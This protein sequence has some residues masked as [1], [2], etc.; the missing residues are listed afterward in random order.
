MSDAHPEDLQDFLEQQLAELRHSVDAG[1]GKV[2]AEMAGRLQ[3][4]ATLRASARSIETIL[5]EH[6]NR[7]VGAEAG[8]I[9][10]NLSADDYRKIVGPHLRSAIEQFLKLEL[11][12]PIPIAM[13]KSA[14][15]I[16]AVQALLE[17][18][19]RKLESRI[20]QFELGVRD[21]LG[22]GS[23]TYNIVHARDVTGGVQQAGR[24]ATQ[25]NFVTLEAE[26]IAEAIDRLEA[27]IAELGEAG[28][29]QAARPDLETLR[30]QLTK[31]T[32]SHPVIRETARSLRTVVE[33]AIGGAVGGAA[34]PALSSALGAL[35]AAVGAA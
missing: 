13:F 20:R 8:W 11:A 29:V 9:G 2:A 16:T 14:D 4:G 31:P 28:F 15:A 21:T 23:T 5:T 27:A 19:R 30:I 18:T 34:T 24:D 35:L 22:A 33:G 10:P 17:L 3:S 1:R 26:R 25:H 32:P 6:V 7:L 12:S